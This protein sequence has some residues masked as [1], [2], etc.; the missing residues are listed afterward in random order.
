MLAQRQTK[1]A[2]LYDQGSDPIWS[3][4]CLKAVVVLIDHDSNLDSDDD[5]GH[6]PF[7]GDPSEPSLRT[8]FMDHCLCILYLR[9]DVYCGAMLT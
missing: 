7:L 8:S 4:N 6:C 9:R 1:E 3:I 2:I 5:T